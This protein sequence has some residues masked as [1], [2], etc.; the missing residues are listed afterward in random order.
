MVGM[1][2]YSN[3][4]FLESPYQLVSSLNNVIYYV[5]SMAYILLTDDIV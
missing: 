4:E 5:L 3:D 2:K 1:L